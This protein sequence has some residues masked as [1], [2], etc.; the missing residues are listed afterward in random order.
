MDKVK[1]NR[2]MNVMQ[3]VLVGIGALNS[4]LTLYNSIARKMALAF[5]VTALV[6]VLAF[7]GIIQYASFGCRKE[8]RFFFAVIFATAAVVVFQQH[9]IQSD[10]NILMTIAFG[11]LMVFAATLKDKTNARCAIMG[12]VFMLIAAGI[13]YTVQ[14][15]KMPVPPEMVGN[16]PAPKKD[17]LDLVSR[18][19][20]FWT[21]PLLA[22]SVGF[23]YEV[24]CNREKTT[25]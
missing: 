9:Q 20:S 6:E 10:T 5:V 15:S 11:C 25:R 22:A 17:F 7:A 4:L 24:K 13:M 23:A 21:S 3:C 8:G 18:Y 12:A 16:L 14:I 1:A 2:F 19:S